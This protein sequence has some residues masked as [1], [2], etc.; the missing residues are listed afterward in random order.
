MSGATKAQ[1]DLLNTWVFFLP[2]SAAVES[3]IASARAG[4]TTPVVPIAPGEPKSPAQFKSQTPSL[5]SIRRIPDSAP[6]RMND[7]SA[8][9]KQLSQLTL[10]SKKTQRLADISFLDTTYHFVAVIDSKD[11][12]IDDD[13]SNL[14]FSAG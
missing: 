12:G 6:L 13:P 11:L 8:S 4:P 2:K 1:M 5:S 3:A 7:D 10:T 14:R 9:E